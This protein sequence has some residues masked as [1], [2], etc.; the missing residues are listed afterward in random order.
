MD[1]HGGLI[2]TAP[3]LC[4]FLH[5]YWI[6]GEPRLQGH[7]QNWVFFG[8]LPGTTAMVRQRRDGVNVAVLL[9][10][11]RDKYIDEDNDS[12]KKAIDLAIDQIRN[13]K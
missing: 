5:G 7:R 3:A 9:N 10:G 12:L 4:E 1:A 2:A 13:G 11:R 8:S 6:S